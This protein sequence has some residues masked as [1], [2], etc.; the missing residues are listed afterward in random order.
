M[1]SSLRLVAGFEM[2]SP[3]VCRASLHCIDRQPV[4]DEQLERVV[5]TRRR[6]IDGFEGSL[7]PSFSGNTLATSSTKTAGE[8]IL[9]DSAAA[10]AAVI[11]GFAFENID[12]VSVCEMVGCGCCGIGLQQ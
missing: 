4:P 2:P 12:L 6:A 10:S 5:Q 8:Y 9:A 11:R 3:A 7:V 1:I